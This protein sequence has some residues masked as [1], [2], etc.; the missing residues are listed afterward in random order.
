MGVQAR[1]GP[2]PDHSE[3]SAKWYTGFATKKAAEADLV[4]KLRQRQ[5]GTFVEPSSLTVAVYLRKWIE[6]YARPNVSGKTFERYKQIV[7]NDLIPGIGSISLHKLQPLQIQNHYAE[8]LQ[9]GQ[10]KERGRSLGS[11]GPA[12]SPRAA[13]GA[14]PGGSWNLLIANPATA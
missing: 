1:A 6:D 5:T 4:A 13:Q 14:R 7:E 11:D 3:A 10:Q 8:Q 12:L 2:R 9:H